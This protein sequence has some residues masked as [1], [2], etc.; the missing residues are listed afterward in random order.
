MNPDWEV[1]VYVP[2]FLYTG[3]STWDNKREGNVPLYTKDYFPDLK[4]NKN[5]K[6][7]EF[8]FSTIGI[9]NNIPEV[10]KS[11]FIRFHLLS[12]VG[13]VWSDSDILY[14]NPI[15]N[16]H[17]NNIMTDTIIYTYMLGNNL[18]HL[19]GLLMSSSNNI[20]YKNVF[21]TA[22]SNFKKS[23]FQS[24]G[25]HMLEKNFP[26][27]DTIKN[28][29]PQLNIENLPKNSVYYIDWV[30]M[31]RHIFSNEDHSNQIL[32]KSDII[33]IHWYGGS[34]FSETLVNKYTKGNTNNI[35]NTITEII[36]KRNLG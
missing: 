19:I 2:K 20:Y 8:D 12:T 11:D 23:D 16:I 34:D 26:N 7:I 13:G 5:I 29:F 32:S 6:V 27:L 21:N 28:K 30:D 22:L 31:Y 14:F 15:Y 36:R 3:A 4:S 1:R 9:D 35:R 25:N 24:C 10:Y 33:G 18:K 17:I